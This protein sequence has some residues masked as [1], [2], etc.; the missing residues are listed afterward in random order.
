MMKFKLVFITLLLS[1]V[2]VFA[3]SPADSTG[4]ENQN[5][6]KVIIH[7]V[8]AH[9]SF[10]SIA[11]RYKV[12]PKALI[13]FNNNAATLSIGQVIKV[14]TDLPFAETAKPNLTAHNDFSVRSSPAMAQQPAKNP[15]A[16]TIPTSETQASTTQYKVA[17]GETLYAISKRFNTTVADI[18]SLNNL[19]STGLAPGQILL[20]RSVPP[21]AT[22]SQ[23]VQQAVTPTVVAP[24]QTVQQLPAQQPPAPTAKRDTTVVASAD[25]VELSHR[26]VPANRYGLLE[27]NEK[28]LGVWMDNDNLDQSKKWVLHRTAP[29]GTV[30]KITNPM[31]NRTTFAKVVG[32]FTDNENTKDALMVMTKSV[33]ESIGAMDKRFHVIISYGT[34]NE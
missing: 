29:I 11:R 31:T 24:K 13:A 2:S 22:T 27:K 23:P 14:S 26:N 5:G 12:D 17:A 3:L 6:K 1:S 18:T 30:I 8:D 9:E 4:V 16:T 19:K 32:R 34:P 21:S 25:S 7:K 20:V 28:G 33:A 10:Y 15:G